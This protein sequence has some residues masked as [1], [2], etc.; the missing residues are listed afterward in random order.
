MLTKTGLSKT[1]FIKT[2]QS[3]ERDCKLVAIV[4]S[5]GAPPP[6]KKKNATTISRPK[7][8]IINQKNPQTIPSEMVETLT[9]AGGV[10]S[11]GRTMTDK[12]R[13]SAMSSASVV[14]QQGKW[15]VRKV[16][17]FPEKWEYTTA[18]FIRGDESSV[19]HPSFVFLSSIAF[20]K[21][22]PFRY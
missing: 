12:S 14:S 11:G 13:T 8:N 20:V 7:P 5:S 17:T 21:S 9:S 1:D 3:Y 16:E 6:P 18:D 22:V 19:I 2:A 10:S 15:T 4:V